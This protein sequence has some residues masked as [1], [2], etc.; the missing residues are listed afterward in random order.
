MEIKEITS[1]TVWET[2][3][4]RYS[5]QALFQSWNWGEVLF[6]TQNLWR[7]GIYDEGK[8][9]GIALIVIIYAKRGVFLHVRHGPIFAK[10]NDRYFD[11]FVKQLTKLAKTKRAVFF[12]ISPLIENNGFNLH[13]MQK[14]GL[15]K[16][17]IHRMDGE[18]CW[19][20]DLTKNE[21]EILANMR[22]TTRYLIRQGQKSNVVITKETENNALDKF[23]CLYRMTAQRQHFIPHIGIKEEFEIFSK[24]KSILLFQGFYQN[25]LLASALIIFYQHQAIYHHSASIQ[26]KIPVNYLLQWEVIKEAKRRKMKVYNMWGIADEANRHHPWLGLTLFK[27]GFGGEKIEYLHAHDFPLSPIYCATKLFETMRKIWKGY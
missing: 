21:E 26:Q 6:Q 8:L 18:V 23:L 1:K 25:Q 10:W 5:P 9:I 22:K 12:R 13:L 19:V 11:F 20:I 24:D 3:L 14:Y 15:K 27:K 2:F 16:S 7:W 17:P 4:A